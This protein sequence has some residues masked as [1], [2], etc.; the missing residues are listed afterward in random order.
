M[1]LLCFMLSHNSTLNAQLCTPFYF[2]VC[3]VLPDLN[4]LTPNPINPG[5][6]HAY[7][8][9]KL[10]SIAGPLPSPW[11][12]NYLAFSG[13]VTVNGFT[14]RINVPLTNQFSSSTG[15]VLNPYF[16]YLTANES[17]EVDWTVGSAAN[18]GSGEP[19]KNLTFLP[20]GTSEVV[21]FTI[22]VDGVPG[23]VIN[24][25]GNDPNVNWVGDVKDC[26][27]YNCT[28]TI[29]VQSCGN[30]LIAF[31][32][33]PV[34]NP[35]R[36]VT[37]DLVQIQNRRYIEVKLNNLTVSESVRRS[38]MVLHILPQMNGI[39]NLE[40][41]PF[42][43][44]G[45]LNVDTFQR[46]NPNTGATDI[47]VKAN[48]FVAGSTSQTIILIEILGQF[49]L[50]QGVSLACSMTPGRGAFSLNGGPNNICSLTA[51][52]ATLNIPG[53]SAC[54]NTLNISPTRYTDSNCKLGVKYTIRHDS[55]T[56]LDFSSLRLR[57]A[58]KLTNGNN[59]PGIPTT[60]LPCSSCGSLAYNATA[61]AWEYTYEQS[62]SLSLPTVSEVLV[63][64]NINVDC[65]RYYVIMA[66]ATPAGGSTCAL[67]VT[68]DINQWPACDPSVQGS[69]IVDKFG[70]TTPAPAYKVNLESTSDPSYSVLKEG[71]CEPGYSFCPDQTKAPFQLRVESASPNDYLCGVTTY[72]LV[73]ISKHILGIG[74]ITEPKTIIAADANKSASI[75]TF[76]IAEIR[77]CILGTQ[78]NFG[79]VSAPSWWYFKDGYTFNTPPLNPPYAG[80]N[81]NA[82]PANGLGNYGVFFAVKVGD[83]NHTCDCG[84]K[85]GSPEDARPFFKVSTSTI[86]RE[87]NDLY[88]PVWSDAPFSLIAAQA[89]F[90]F[91]PSLLS[92][93]AVI[94]NQEL[95]IYNFNFGLN[96]E[97]DGELKFAW[98][99]L[100]GQTPLP[101]K[102]L[103]FTL[104]FETKDNSDLAHGPLLWTSEDILKG[105][106]YQEDGTEYPVRLNWEEKTRERSPSLGLILSP[107]PFEDRMT[108]FIYVE[109]PV[110]AMIRLSDG[111]GFIF[112]QQTIELKPGD[113]AVEIQTSASAQPGVYF[114][115]IEVDGQKFQR[116]VVKI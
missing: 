63:P 84:M 83:V 43:P 78:P 8:K 2:E 94:P 87:G 65:I 26:N 3:K 107:N 27:L 21:L 38:D 33:P 29:P 39:N 80:S 45:A 16:Q 90:R 103:L 31:L 72:D 99:Q 53:F 48:L 101:K 64:F 86:K 79:P 14:S 100:D 69:I 102:E 28:G 70:V 113:N 12:V 57:F 41:K 82:V 4:S 109:N 61:D 91:D 37:F 66:E 30:N 77:K 32:A 71:D 115:S 6:F 24:F 34:C 17:G 58:F 19:G 51:V 60:T 75:T 15:G 74:T 89:G 95:D 116:K 97:A 85:P 9:V 73:L 105:L 11:N 5:A 104:Q 47:Y 25:K 49:N 35:N 42:I 36:D 22:V 23:D 110:K 93:K 54:S 55:P 81:I 52:P 114:L 92:L 44:V 20:A 96:K 62:T 67:G 108:A 50:S 40:L 112:T 13:K 7:Y 59:S 56:P 10:K 1:L 76:D 111:K 46:D 88:V 106:S 98:S 68:F 18:C